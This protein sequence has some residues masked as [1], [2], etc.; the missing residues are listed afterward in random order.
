[1]ALAF[2]PFPFNVGF[3]ASL[4][5]A[6]G[7]TLSSEIGSL[8]KEKPV[9]ITTLSLV[10]PGE[11]GGV[12]I[13]GF[14]ASMLGGLLY[15]VL[16]YLITGNISWI[17]IM[18]LAGLLGSTLDSIIGA[19]LQRGEYI[20]NNVTNFLAALFIGVLFAYLF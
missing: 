20:D 4:A 11:D 12:T 10:Y 13:L 7:D 9:L 15:G 18:T 17:G 2:N 19:T 3:F 14:L 1:V 6:F 8:S 5:A 16:C